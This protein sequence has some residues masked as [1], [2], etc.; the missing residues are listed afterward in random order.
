MH[1]EYNH[2]PFTSTNW[3]H[4]YIKCFDILLM[5]RVSNTL[6]WNVMV[7]VDLV[8]CAFVNTI[9]SRYLCTVS[10]FFILW[11]LFL[12]VDRYSTRLVGMSCWSLGHCS[13]FCQFISRPHHPKHA[14]EI[15]VINSVCNSLFCEAFSVDLR[16]ATTSY[17]CV[18]SYQ[19]VVISV[20]IWIV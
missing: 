6:A 11:I 7:R 10:L 14:K 13:L 3:L 20:R 18:I 19:C 15:Y 5:S 12:C 9:A 8:H 2:F 1:Y 16:C 17:Q 4:N